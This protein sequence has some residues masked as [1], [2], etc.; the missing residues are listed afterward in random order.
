MAAEQQFRVMGSDAHLIVVGGSAG[1]VS[2]ARA[3]IEDLERKWSRFLDDSEIS[4]LNRCAG[5][6]L[7][8]SWETARLVERAIDGWRMSAGSFDP[9]VL[10]PLVR[11]GYD[12]SIDLLGPSVPPRRSN[13]A[14]GA[15]DIRVEGCS[16]G[17][18]A[19]TGFDPGGIGKGLAADIVCEETMAAGAAGVCVNLGG[20]VRVM[21]SGP[22]GG[23]WTVAVEHPWASSPILL[24]GLADGAVAT[25]TTLRRCWTT[26]GQIR[27]HIIDPYTERPSDTDLN[28]STVIA[29]QGWMAE[30]L[31][32]AVLLAGAAH[33]FDIL[34]GSGAQGIAVD[35]EGGLALTPGTAAFLGNQAVPPPLARPDGQS[36]GSRRL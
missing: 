7:E 6:S 29:G 1:L 31:A 9:T 3:R 16:V 13:L 22:A 27:H 32:K 28:L 2:E 25:T 19:G 23:S 24:L 35:D 36:L 15:A 5:S 10:G 11:A 34:G 30:V 33:P 18:P 14:L 8:V 17:L 12:R 26:E 20:D 4:Q 21:G